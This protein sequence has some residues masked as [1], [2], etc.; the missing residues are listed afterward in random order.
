MTAALGAMTA[1]AIVMTIGIG[2]AIVCGM[3]SVTVTAMNTTMRIE[4]T[5]GLVQNRR[6]GACAA[7][8]GL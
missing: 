7:Q 3:K 6:G 5:Q 1:A 8:G 4:P 2:V